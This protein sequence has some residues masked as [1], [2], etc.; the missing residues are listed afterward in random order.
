MTLMQ[1]LMGLH[2]GMMRERMDAVPDLAD[3]QRRLQ[4][5]RHE[6]RDARINR[7]KSENGERIDR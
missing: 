7:I 2:S 3:E 4:E 1:S 5:E 6:G